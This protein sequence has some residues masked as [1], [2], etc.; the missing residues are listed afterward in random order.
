MARII[1]DNPQEEVAMKRTHLMKH[2]LLWFWG[3]FFGFGLGLITG[4]III[5]ILRVI[6][7]ALTGRGDS[8][9]EW[10]VWL[11]TPMSLLIFSITTFISMR[12][13]I[14]GIREYIRRQ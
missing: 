3:I 2:S 14:K 1:N 12:W 4:L 8:E 7:S 5:V 13:S 11:Y 6:L 9:S 10:V